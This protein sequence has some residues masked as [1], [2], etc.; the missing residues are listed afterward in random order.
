MSVPIAGA[1]S[2]RNLCGRAQ[3]FGVAQ[4]DD[5]DRAID[6]LRAQGV[7]FSSRV[8]SG[9]SDPVVSFAPAYSLD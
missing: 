7:V 3:A 4:L 5:A 1:I 9:S 6:E 8:G 2:R